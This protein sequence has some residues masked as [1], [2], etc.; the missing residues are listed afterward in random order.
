MS[1]FWDASAL[2]HVCVPGQISRT[3]RDLVRANVI[4]V[5]WRTP[6]EVLSVLNPVHREAAIPRK[7]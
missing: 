4:A 2:V 1:V 5:W 3:A 6:L 7:P